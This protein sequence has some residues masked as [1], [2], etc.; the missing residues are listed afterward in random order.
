MKSKAEILDAAGQAALHHTLMKSIR[1]RGHIQID[2]DP[3]GE[4]ELSLFRAGF[5][6]PV[7]E[8]HFA[9]DVVGEG[10]QIRKRLAVAGLQDWRFD[11][12]IPTM[13]IAI[14][15]D[16][17][18]RL[19]RRGPRGIMVGGRHNGPKDMMKLN[20]AQK[21]GWRVFR[22]TN[23]MV[24]DGTANLF[25]WNLAADIAQKEKAA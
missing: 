21:L 6:K 5:P 11:I 19:I 2:S 22:F 23:E 7:R 12:A 8:Y 3:T 20:H 14:E 10:K 4:I 15:L 16:G 25:I 1:R 13:K 24:K 17:G 18:T 9:R